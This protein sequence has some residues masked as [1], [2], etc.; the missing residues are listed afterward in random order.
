MIEQDFGEE[1]FRPLKIY[2]GATIAGGRE[3]EKEIIRLATELE[4]QGHQ[5]VSKDVVFMD[6][7][8][9]LREEA[10]TSSNYYQYIA[11]H[12][13]RQMEEADVGIFEISQASLGVGFEVCY[14]AYVLTKP[15]VLLINR[16]TDV[17]SATLLGDRSPLIKVLE[18]GER[19]SSFVLIRA[20]EWLRTEA[21]QIQTNLIN[22]DF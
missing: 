22:P 4:E 20:L 18:Y 12:H 3:N 10:K 6:L 5:V 16:G 2:F 21:R 19:G 7:Q 9:N 15:I 8:W 13:K 1:K 17:K 14:M 11:E